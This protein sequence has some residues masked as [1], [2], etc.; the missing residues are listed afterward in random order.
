MTPRQAIAEPSSLTSKLI[1]GW[2]AS[3]E[4]LEHWGKKHE[5]ALSQSELHEDKISN[6]MELTAHSMIEPL[7]KAKLLGSADKL[8]KKYGFSDMTQWANT[9]L[10]ITKAAAAIELESEPGMMDTSKL[11][12]LKKNPKISTE[13]KEMIDKAIKQNNAMMA[14]IISDTSAEDKKTIKP[15][16]EKILKLMDKPY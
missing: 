10:K 6:P 11:E 14:Q 16:L 8:V 15:F 3:Q 12:A 9:T 1:E 2:M 7:R 4:E 5:K 13:Q